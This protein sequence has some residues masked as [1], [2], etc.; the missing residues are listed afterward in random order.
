MRRLASKACYYHKGLT[1]ISITG[2]PIAFI[3]KALLSRHI[4]LISILYGKL[5]TVAQI[6]FI[7][8][9]G[10]LWEKLNAISFPCIVPGLMSELIFTYPGVKNKSNNEV[11]AACSPLNRN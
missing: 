3:R 11:T 8:D 5:A 1:G 7:A 4:N 2:K 9:G 10:H 6:S